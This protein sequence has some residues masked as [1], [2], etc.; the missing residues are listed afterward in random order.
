MNQN[1]TEWLPD[2]PAEVVEGARGHELCP[3]I[4]AL[5]G[6]RRG[7]TLKWYT[8]E[9]DKFDHMKVWYVDRPGRLFSLS[10]AERTHYFFRSRG[11]KVTNEA[12]EIGADKEKSKEWLTKAGVSVPKGRRFSAEVENREIIEYATQQIGFPLV[13]KPTD[14]SFGRGVVTKI[15]TTEELEVALILVRS[16]LQYPDVIVEQFIPGHDYRLYVVGDKVVGAIQRIPANVIGDGSSTVQQ[17]IELKNEERKK[18]PRLFSCLIKIDHEMNGVLE[19]AGYRVTSIPKKGEVVY[20]SEKSNISLGGDSIDVLDQLSDEVKKTAVKAIQAVPDLYHGGVDIII[21]PSKQP[22]GQ[23]IVLELNPTSQL[24]SLVYPMTGKGR[25]VP[26]A[27]IDFYFPES[28]N[29]DKTN[30]YFDF[31]SVLQPLVSQTA[32]EVEVAPAQLG[33]IYAKK[34]RVVGAVQPVAFHQ[35]LRKRALEMGLNGFISNIT[36]ESIDVVV[37]GVSSD[38]VNQYKEIIKLDPKKVE[39]SEIQEESWEKPVRIGFEIQ[40]ELKEII[41]EIAKTRK[42]LE[43]LEK[44]RNRVEQ[45]Y[46]ALQES[47]IWRLTLPFR[48]LLDIVKKV[49]RKVT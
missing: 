4:I 21:D 46:L 25:D 8:K 13:V 11:D 32:I 30:L 42:E 16:E 38:S 48:K 41:A 14:G 5:E 40:A 28:V 12:L 3:Y 20:L 27:I 33:K 15:E 31:K 35:W 26:G 22:E 49:K 43:S 7:L 34:Y 44:K 1:K 18:N 9:S 6:W 36:N 23:A 29:R 17:L 2:L 45:Q 19:D 24:G 37:A 47:R 39:I 10:S